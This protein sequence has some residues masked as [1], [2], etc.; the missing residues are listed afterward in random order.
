MSPMF[1]ELLKISRSG[2]SGSSSSSSSSSNNSSSFPALDQYQQFYCAKYNTI[3]SRGGSGGGMNEVL[4]TYDSS[5]LWIK[6]PC[7]ISLVPSLLCSV[8]SK[9][10]KRR[11]RAQGP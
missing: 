1:F 11:F 4:A 2:G 9:P 3:K 7:A 5:G 8:S 6:S 10:V